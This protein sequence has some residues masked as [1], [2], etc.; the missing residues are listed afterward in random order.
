MKPGS[1][2]TQ[3]LKGKLPDI[4]SGLRPLYDFMPPYRKRQFLRVLMLM[5]V[6]ALAEIATI[7]A[8]VPFL[9]LLAS[10]GELQPFQGF[11]RLFELLG[12]QTADEQ[13][14]ASTILFMATAL[15]AAAIRLLLSWSTQSFVLGLGHNLSAEI[16]RRILLQPYSF[17]ISRNSSEI[18]ASLD[19]VQ[20]LV[21]GVLLQ[22]MLAA[23]SAFMAI[24]IIAALVYVDPF[25][26]VAAAIAFGGMYLLVS[27]FTRR[28]LARNSATMGAA[29]QQ[30][31]QIIQESLGGIRD[32][33]IDHSQ[34]VYLDAFREIDRRFM[35]ARL[36]TTFIATAPRFVIE[37]AGMV[38][39]AAI[40]LAMSGREGGLAV[41][42]PILGALA[43]GAQRLL[44][45]MQ[46][47]YHGWTNLSGNRAVTR[48]V[49]DLLQL[50]ISKESAPVD[51]VPS[52]PFEDFL[53]FK[54]VD[55][56][57][58]G[59]R[60][61]A[62]EDINLTIPS[63]SSVALVGKTGSGKTTLADLLMGLL[64][65]SAGE[66][67]IDGVA[68]TGETR[69]AWQRSIAHVPQSVFLSDTSISR[70]IAFGVPL[71]E[72]DPERVRAAATA[73]QIDEFVR[74][75]PEG[76]DTSIGERGVRLSGGQRQRLGIARAI[77]KDAPVFVLD[78]ATSAL[79]GATE[80][81]VLAALDALRQNGRTI[82]IVAHRQSTIENCELVARLENG[83]L[84]DFGASDQVLARLASSR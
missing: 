49:L 24:F 37:A 61:A 52:L 69:R 70:N 16:Q 18:I 13:L 46:Q 27:L 1:D 84:V 62:L 80:A 83:R 7:G 65:P 22:L 5:L 75:L 31:V 17:H 81:A 3:A 47:V 25:T 32:V 39:I 30:R 63:G 53:C 82:I 23:T 10:Q 68:L 74:S 79:D 66:I 57:Y 76:Y 60:R 28:R 29:Y 55:F 26:A 8:V 50:P 21:S 42:L 33:I 15:F 64:D 59:L 34:R 2:H 19:K 14:V 43:L 44:P 51:R 12:A 40:A 9:S 48:Q 4:M 45:L 6:G 56:S 78:E 71:A 41:A 77:Y 67:T 35:W 11:S 58:P 36:T 73:A 38:V 54:G 72:I 20:V